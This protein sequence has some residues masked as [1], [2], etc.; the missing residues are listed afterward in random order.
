MQVILHRAGRDTKP[1]RDLLVAEASSNEL[2]NLS[3]ALRKI[4][5]PRIR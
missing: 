3:L 5:E 1:V 4:G 2:R